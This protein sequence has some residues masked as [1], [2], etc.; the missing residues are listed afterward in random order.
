MA[1]LDLELNGKAVSPPKNW[2]GINVL[3]TWD[4]GSA[5]ANIT[6]ENFQLVQDAAQEV[7]NWFTDG[8]RGNGNGY[9]QGIPARILVSEGTN[10]KAVF[11]GFTDNKTFVDQRTNDTNKSLS[12][13]ISFKQNDQIIN[14]KSRAAG[15]TFDIV[16]A[17]N[18]LP[19]SMIKELLYVKQKPFDALEAFAI[20]VQVAMMALTLTQ[21]IKDSAKAIIEGVAHTTGGLAGLIAGPLYVVLNLAINIASVIAHLVILV[22]QINQLLKIFLPM[23]RKAGVVSMFDLAS[24]ASSYLGFEF[25][26]SLKELKE[27]YILPT[28]TESLDNNPFVKSVNDK[29]YF[30]QNDSGFIVGDY[31]K[32][33]EEIFGAKFQI[34]DNV[35]NFENLLN[36]NYWLNDN[37]SSY[38][39]PDVYT[40]QNVPNGAETSAGLFVEFAN[41]DLDEWTRQN[42]EGTFSTESITHKSSENPVQSQLENLDRIQIPYALGNAK[43]KVNA[44]EAARGGLVSTLSAIGKVFGQK[45]SKISEVFANIKQALKISGDFTSKPK[46]LCLKDAV[47]ENEEFKILKPTH[48]KELNA[49][50]II[51][52]NGEK[53]IVRND[54]RNQWLI[55]N[56]IIIPFGF[57]DFLAVGKNNYFKNQDGATVKINSVEWQI[58]ADK[59]NVSYRIRTPYD[60]NLKSTIYTGKK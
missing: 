22:T 30:T 41:D 1:R 38:K 2:R 53:S 24:S 40:V 21:V 50:R 55:F 11:N 18:F 7:Y 19:D 15:V 37:N 33:I 10:S 23:P 13:E 47:V 14:F 16:K 4:N 58:G 46:I 26:S 51:E 52:L 39:M 49:E 36:D 34:K 3:M 59:A 60:R 35:A 25:K 9:F 20:S 17:E 6:T 32:N 43:E 56:D 57:S 8:R 54:F 48:R 45:P 29:G 27:W 28:L 44:I 5:Q 31:F 42:L 12:C